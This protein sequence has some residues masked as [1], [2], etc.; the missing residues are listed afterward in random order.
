[1]ETIPHLR[2]LLGLC[3][4]IKGPIPLSFINEWNLSDEVQLAFK[5]KAMFLFNN[6]GNSLSFFH[7]SFRQFLLSKTA[8]SILTGEFDTNRDAAF[9]AD[10]AGYYQK[11]KIEPKWNASYHL[12]HAGKTDEFLQM[13]NPNAFTEQLLKFRSDQEIDADIKTGLLV[14]Q[15]RNDPNITLRYLLSLNELESRSRHTGVSSYVEEFIQLGNIDQAK[16]LIRNDTQLL[17]NKSYALDCAQW[18]FDAGEK[19]EAKRVCSRHTGR[20]H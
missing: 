14:G 5:R 19:Q 2:Q 20:S 18:L 10:L 16:K 4:K 6:V 12:Y 1:M 8:A 11:S 13:A 9:H 7:N 3:A 15:E 17:V